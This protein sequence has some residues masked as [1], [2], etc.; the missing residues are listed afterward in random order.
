[1]K[2]F[3]ALFFLPLSAHSLRGDPY[4]VHREHRELDMDI[5]DDY[6]DSKGKHQK[7]GKKNSEKRYSKHYSSVSTKGSMKRTK[8]QMKGS[9]VKGEKSRSYK[10]KTDKSGKVKSTN[11][12][13]RRSLRL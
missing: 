1:M 13:L 12:A 11:H 10:D 6:V 3:F 5:G 8:N 9:S 4:H 2:P 7:S